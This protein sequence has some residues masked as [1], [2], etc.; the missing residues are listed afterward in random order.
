MQDSL[1]VRD[2]GEIIVSGDTPSFDSFTFCAIEG[3][4]VSP[5]ALVA[6]MVDESKFL[7]GRVSGG[8]E[9]AETD[10]ETF[11]TNRIY[12]VDV[13][14]E[15]LISRQSDGNNSIVM[16]EPCDLA[17]AGAPV[18]VPG[19]DIMARAIGFATDPDRS[20]RLGSTR[21]RAEDA[22]LAA[23]GESIDNVLLSSEV[24]HRHIF[25]SGTTG[26]GKS[27]ASGILI[28]EMSKLGMPVI[29]FDSQ[30]EYA[31]L[32]R[33]LGGTVL[34]PGT[35]Y[36][37]HLSSLT[38]REI[39]DL[40]PTLKGTSMEDLLTYTFLRLK[41]EREDWTLNDLLREMAK[42]G[43]S[44]QLP[45]TT[46]GPAISRVRHHVGRHSFLGEPSDWERLLRKYKIVNID[47]GRLDQTQ[48]QFIVTATLRDLFT[49]RLDG[50][51]PPYVVVLEEAHLLVPENEPSPCK[52]VIRENVRMGR[53]YGV[54]VVLITQSPV[55]I[56][57]KTIRQCNTRLVFALD[58]DQLDALQGVRSDATEDMLKR[59]PKMPVGTCLLSGTYQTIK[60]AIPVRV[61]A[62][63][64]EDA[65]GVTPDSLGEI[66][67]QW[68]ASATRVR[69]EADS[70]ADN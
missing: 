6:T 55:D 36:T 46:S 18:F 5:G 20:I 43:P 54:C 50:R 2:V 31:A 35:D 19:T 56:D 12:V 7:V 13:M 10:D 51:I 60:H 65:A 68:S 62:S 1:R 70:W 38:D 48:L 66:E 64:R 67:T 28:E 42:D 44:L 69:P 17:T 53:H 27:Y 41:R 9:L 30:K 58:P 63:E 34:D 40:V 8:H 61:R 25:I 59:L 24:L 11:A 26:T 29:I 33:G 16:I 4:Y 15:G 52:Q 23:A 47:C 21:V 49:A 39:S 14:E 3:E 32:T 22:L 57:R 37:V 45:S